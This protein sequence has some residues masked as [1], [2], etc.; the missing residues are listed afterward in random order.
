MG[1]SDWDGANERSNAGCK[2]IAGRLLL[3]PLATKAGCTF[4]NKAS[5]V[6][7][8]ENNSTGMS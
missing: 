3:V 1:F 2:N 7:L 4:F 5:A 6:E 8:I